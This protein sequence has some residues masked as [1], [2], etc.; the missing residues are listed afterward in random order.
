LGYKLSFFKGEVLSLSQADQEKKIND[1]IGHAGQT[2][3]RLQEA[4][5]QYR[6]NLLAAQQ[7]AGQQRAP[8][9]G[10]LRVS[11]P[12]PSTQG[13]I[14]GTPPAPVARADSYVNIVA[15]PP[16]TLIEVTTQQ[17]V[18]TSNLQGPY[19]A[20]TAADIR[21][22]G[23]TRVSKGS[24]A[25]LTILKVGNAVQMR[26]G[27]LVVNGAWVPLNTDSISLSTIDQGGPNANQNLLIDAGKSYKFH[28][29]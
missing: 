23:G 19:G 3:Q 2:L 14:Q 24:L 9:A 15:I 22:P 10:A 26:L 11:G 28:Q 27:S 18:D 7:A 16:G 1:L 17:A 21:L 25:R 20:A 29:L 6:A 4:Q 8:V 13:A 12:S 5:Q